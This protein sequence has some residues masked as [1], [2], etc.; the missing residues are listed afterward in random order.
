MTETNST[1]ETSF[2]R[3]WDLEVKTWS[4]S[5]GSQRSLEYEVDVRSSRVD[6]SAK[7]VARETV[8]GH[9]LRR[10]LIETRHPRERGETGHDVGTSNLYLHLHTQKVKVKTLRCPRHCCT[11]FTCAVKMCYQN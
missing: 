4:T 5:F 10:I 7:E 8:Y 11:K 2:C 3:R 6:D 1:P 9:P